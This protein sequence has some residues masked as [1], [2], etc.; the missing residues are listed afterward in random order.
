MRSFHVLAHAQTPRVKECFAPA[1]RLRKLGYDRIQRICGSLFGAYATVATGEAW[2][3]P[4]TS[5]G[6]LSFQVGE[7]TI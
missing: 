5:H 6:G 4:C 3:E 2:Y 7:G 1:W